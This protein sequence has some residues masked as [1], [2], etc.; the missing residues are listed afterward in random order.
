MRACCYGDDAPVPCE[1]MHEGSQDRH[2]LD[3]SDRHQL[4]WHG[5]PKVM[6]GFGGFWLPP[7]RSFGVCLI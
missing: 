1:R 5:V 2:R 6:V 3:F 4:D 7:V